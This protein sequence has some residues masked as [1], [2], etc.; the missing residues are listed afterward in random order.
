M[1]AANTQQ[2]SLGLFFDTALPPA[3]T[4]ASGSLAV[5]REIARVVGAAI[6]DSG[7]DRADI[8]RQ[9]SELLGR[10]VTVHMLNAYSSEAREEHKINLE[11]A[12]AFDQATGS[13]ALLQYFASKCG[14][15]AYIGRDAL[16][17]ELGKAEILRDELTGQIKR[18]K[19]QMDSR[20]EEKR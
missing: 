19:Q 9:M 12:I 11:R 20:V 3:P 16:L 17:A 13:F 10:E 5:T 2:L 7:I 4:N 14:G 6:A 15:R 18:I 1:R 8:A